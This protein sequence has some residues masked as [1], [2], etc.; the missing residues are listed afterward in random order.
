[1]GAESASAL[2]ARMVE[3]ACERVQAYGIDS[4]TEQLLFVLESATVALAAQGIL[5]T[6]DGSAVMFRIA[7]FARGHAVALRAWRAGK[8]WLVTQDGLS[9]IALAP[10]RFWDILGQ[11]SFIAAASAAMGFADDHKSLVTEVI[12]AARTNPSL[13]RIE[14]AGQYPDIATVLGTVAQMDRPLATAVAKQLLDGYI[15]SSAAGYRPADVALDPKELGRHLAN[16]YS[17]TRTIQSANERPADEG[18]AMLLFFLA[19]LMDSSVELSV[20]IA[21]LA[22]EETIDDYYLYEP[23]TFRAQF[24][25]TMHDCNIMHWVRS[26]LKS[27]SKMLDDF[28]SLPTSAFS[29][30]LIDSARASVASIAAGRHFRNRAGFWTFDTLAKQ[31]VV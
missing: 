14:W 22:A 30:E 20:L 5:D 9:A 7:E 29:A 4:D 24:S 17:P 21:K 18:P 8:G 23:R 31:N 19:R 2:I 12:E 15:R 27:A 1:M 6:S 16:K 3:S 13:W 11:A 28:S 25:R 26:S 10:I